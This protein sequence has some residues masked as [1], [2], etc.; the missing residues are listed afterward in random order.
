MG[1]APD[2]PTSFYADAT[3]DFWSGLTSVSLALDKLLFFA[4]QHIDNSQLLCF[5]VVG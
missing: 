3:L 4:K 5:F 1:V 2:V